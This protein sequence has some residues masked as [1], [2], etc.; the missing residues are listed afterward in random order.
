M[1]M[2]LSVLIN[3]YKILI[4]IMDSET[5][6][7]TKLFNKKDLICCV[8]LETLIGEIYQCSSGPHYICGEC[9]NEVEKCPICRKTDPFHRAF[10]FENDL[11]QF[12]INCPNNKNNCEIK[13]FTWELTTH[14]KICKYNPLECPH[15][16]KIIGFEH[17][18]FYDCKKNTDEMTIPATVLPA[19]NTLEIPNYKTQLN[20]TASEQQFE[21][22]FKTYNEIFL[23]LKN[24]DT[25]IENSIETVIKYMADLQND[26]KKKFKEKL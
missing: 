5:I 6:T 17:K 15:C 10:E 4:N 2:Q 20:E 18:K 24:Q 19:Q 12:V 21:D 11:K 13:L 1:K 22:Y 25:E 23:N 9:S 16:Q 8:C 14:L 3:I 26:Y 7:I